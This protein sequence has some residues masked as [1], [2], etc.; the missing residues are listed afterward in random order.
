MGVFLIIVIRRA[1][2]GY[3][4]AED[5]LPSEV[6]TLVQEFI[7]GQ[8]LYVPKKDAG[9]NTWGSIS[10]TKEYLEYRNTQI[11][12]EYRA[13]CSVHLLAEKY[14]LSVKSIQRIVRTS[15]PS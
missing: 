14:C 11:C 15:R 13:G 2:M 12:T 4:R 10:G 7:D 1:I 6:L 5:V 3:I 9:R 8:M